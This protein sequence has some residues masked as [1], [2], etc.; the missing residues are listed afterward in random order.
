MWKAGAAI[1]L[2]GVWMW[3]VVYVAMEIHGGNDTD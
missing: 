3:F 2:V 1:V